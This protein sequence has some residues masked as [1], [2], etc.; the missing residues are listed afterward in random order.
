MTL[1]EYASKARR[2][3]NGI[4][5]IVVAALGLAGEAGEFAEMVKKHIAQGHLI[6][7]DKLAEEIGDILW[8]CV[9]AAD[10]I[11][12]SLDDIAQQNIRKLKERYPDGF[13]SERSINR[14]KPIDRQIPNPEG[15]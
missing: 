13:S 15:G 3:S 6:S 5:S 10:A 4:H 12:V 1:N 2:T 14:N 8:Y 9:L 7:T 11:G